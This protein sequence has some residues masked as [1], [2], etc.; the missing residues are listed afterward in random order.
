M[1]KTLTVI[2]PVFLLL[3][4]IAGCSDDSTE[5]TTGMLTLDIS[6]LGNLGS[7][8]AYEGWLLV[9]DM[10]VSTGTFT[11][12]DAGDLSQTEFEVDLDDLNTAT[13]F[14]L[15]IEPS[16]DTD[17]DPSST[18]YI[19]GDFS[20]GMATLS[21]AD[22]AALGDDFSDVEGTYI[23]ATPTNGSET[24]EDS[25][26]WF[27]DL[28]GGSPAVGFMML[29]DL[30]DGWKYEGWAVIDGTPVT[31]GKF[32]SATGMDEVD[33]YSGAM[34]GP[35][36]PGEDFLMNAPTGLTFPTEDLLGGAAVITIEPDPD[37]STAPFAMKPLIGLI[38]TNAT[39]HTNYDMSLN[40]DSLPTGTA[41]R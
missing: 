9:D 38:P 7:N 31:T 8:Y 15:T 13:K 21:V 26:I 12:N 22:A 17:A 23:L 35:P 27:L 11:V 6:G 2:A 1:K 24:N 30:P 14:I 40:L 5:P 36:F 33:P 19:A 39:D 37:N 32:T 4:L 25:G 41:S 16:P 10:P 3:A 34:D 28:S 18:H 20:D 29:P